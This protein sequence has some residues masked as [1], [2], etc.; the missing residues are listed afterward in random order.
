MAWTPLRHRHLQRGGL[1]RHSLPAREFQT[2]R[3]GGVVVDHTLHPRVKNINSFYNISIPCWHGVN[4]CPTPPRPPSPREGW[5]NPISHWQGS[6]PLYS[7]PA[8]VSGHF[9][10]SAL[11]CQGGSDPSDSSYISGREVIL[12]LPHT[13]E[14]ARKLFLLRPRLPGSSCLPVSYSTSRSTWPLSCLAAEAAGLSSSIGLTHTCPPGRPTARAAGR[15]T[16]TTFCSSPWLFLQLSFNVT[17]EHQ[18][19][20]A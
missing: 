5:P 13:T 7:S 8:E 1:R 9:S 11:A 20:S 17:S 2:T 14:V 15:T 6:L 12:R 3:A 19:T 4:A 16:R 18:K 10:V